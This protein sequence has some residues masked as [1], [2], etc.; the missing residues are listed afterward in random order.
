[1]AWK[2][3]DAWGLTD[4]LSPAFMKSKYKDVMSVT[5]DEL[6]AWWPP[7][8][9]PSG[10]WRTLVGV[11]DHLHGQPEHPVLDFGERAVALGNVGWGL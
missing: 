8:L 6:D 4:T 1:M 11:I 7:T 10:L 9:A 2:T 5:T 3:G